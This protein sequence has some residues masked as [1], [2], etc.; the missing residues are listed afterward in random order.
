MPIEQLTPMSE[1]EDYLETQIERLR[2]VAIRNLAYVGERCITASRIGGSYTD[3]TGNLRSSTGYTLIE[4]GR[5]INVGGFEIERKG[6]D[7]AKSGETYA[8]KIASKYPKGLVLIVVAGMN[9]AAYV[10]A[11]GY[12]VLD[13]AELLAEQLVPEL[14][15][16][17]EF[18]KR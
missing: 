6:G 4:D 1:V 14:M 13:S 17:L 9:Y 16:K 3:Q 11:K 5:I 15:K 7:G 2:N 8:K 12:D 10:S 18:K